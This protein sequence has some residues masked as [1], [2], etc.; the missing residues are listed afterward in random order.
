MTREII[1]KTN[2]SE[3][4]CRTAFI[5][6][7]GKKDFMRF[8]LSIILDG[9]EFLHTTGS[10]VWND[11][12]NELDGCFPVAV[13]DEEKSRLV[14]T[15]ENTE[16]KKDGEKFNVNISGLNVDENDEI[17]ILQTFIHFLIEKREI[18]VEIV[19]SAISE[20]LDE[21]CPAIDLTDDSEEENACDGCPAF[22]EYSPTADENEDTD[23]TAEEACEKAT[24]AD[25]ENRCEKST[26]VKA[27]EDIP[28]TP[29]GAEAKD[30]GECQPEYKGEIGDIRSTGDNGDDITLM[31]ADKP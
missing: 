4:E 24:C 17:N 26:E 11:I 31:S 19:I 28:C 16:G 29:Y 5:N 21:H 2:N 27:S 15:F 9:A 6:I 30:C 8:M 10:T 13:G 18:P 14:F 20:A 1:C 7:C 12:K 25:C 22:C 23:N 3:S